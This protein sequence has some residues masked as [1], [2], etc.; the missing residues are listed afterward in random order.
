MYTG[1][2]GKMKSYPKDKEYRYVSIARFNKFWSGEEYKKL[3]PPASIIKIEDKELYTK[4]YY[5]QV[6]NNLNPQEVYNELGDNAVLLC[7]EKYADIEQGKTFCHRHMV[8]KWLEEKL[9]V[10][11]KELENENK[12]NSQQLHF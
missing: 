7:Y 11:V 3:T 12:D 5:E 1:Y 9:G 6:L 4:L 2:F 10:E 8:A